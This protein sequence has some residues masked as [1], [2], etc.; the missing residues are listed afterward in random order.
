MTILDTQANFCLAHC[1]GVRFFLHVC[2]VMWIWT[3]VTR[4]PLRGHVRS[5]LIEILA[6]PLPSHFIIY[7]CLL[8]LSVLVS[9]QVEG[10]I[11]QSYGVIFLPLWVWNALTFA[12]TIGGVVLWI[13]KKKLR[14]WWWWWL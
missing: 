8:L 2:S 9:L 14:Y 4:R 3:M 6:S 1:H 10:V 12:G 7:D 5:S 11:S 13:R